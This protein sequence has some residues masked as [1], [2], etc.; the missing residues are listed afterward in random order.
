MTKALFPNEHCSPPFR[1]ADLLNLDQADVA[2]LGTRDPDRHVG[3]MEDAAILSWTAAMRRGDFAS[4]WA[5]S[6]A[7]R[8]TADRARRDDPSLPYH[9]RW[10]WDGS[11]VAGRDVL[12]RCYHGLGDTLQFARFLP[13][14]ATR[15]ASVTL[16]VQ[17][18]LV[19]LLAAL[20]GIHRLVA[21]DPANPI[22]AAACTLEITD[23]SEALALTPDHASASYLTIDPAPLPGGTIGLCHRAGDWDDARSLEPEL[24]APLCGLAPAV[25]LVTEPCRLSV[26]NP[27]GCPFDM[28]ETA[29]LVSGC[30]LVITVDTMIAHLAGTLGRP[31][32]LL[33]KAA[34]DWRWVPGARSSNWYPAMRLYHQPSPGD[35]R[36][37]LAEV[38]RDL[39]A[40]VRQVAA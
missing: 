21:F 25:T 38:E 6:A 3:A 9:Q 16:E 10:V 7:V 36:S 30:A 28:V 1:N 31:T 8:V 40:L 13:A 37:V 24:F 22:P 5:I 18:S 14:L 20:P 11:T 2:S 23:L 39:A 27:D 26:I 29:R 4:A 19:P 32:W 34:P 33:L 17:K 12:V 35:W 15:A